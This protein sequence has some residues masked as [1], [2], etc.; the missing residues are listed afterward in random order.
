MKEFLSIQEFSKL[1]GIEASTLRYWDD[2]GLFPPIK[3]DPQNNYRYYSP[4]QII[5]VK[6]ITVMSE[7]S[8]SL[9]MI[10]DIE[11]E[12][13]PEKIVNLIEQQE[14]RLNLEMKRLR[15]CHSIIHTRREYIN[16]GMHVVNGF[17]SVNGMMMDSSYSG[18]DSTNV[19]LDTISILHLNDEAYILGPP[20]NFKENEGFF[21]PF[22]NFCQQADEYRINLSFPIGGYHENFESFM[23]RPSAPDYF[24]SMDLTGNRIRKAGQYLVGFSRGFYGQFNN[25]PERMMAY[26]KENALKVTGP[27]I[28]VYLHDETCIDDPSQYVSQI[29]VAVSSKKR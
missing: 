19:G 11:H 2:I 4:M 24:I 8:V 10:S 27:V 6:F 5:S 14:K 26:I 20:N 9:K 3:R 13:N 21:E 28:A 29:S 7:L 25:L 18:T 12:R 16:Y 23:A 15:E 22:T 17:T 1:S